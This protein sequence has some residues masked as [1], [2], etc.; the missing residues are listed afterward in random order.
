MKCCF[1]FS[2]VTIQIKHTYSKP[3]TVF[4]L[5]I[6]SKPASCECEEM[7]QAKKKKCEELCCHTTTVSDSLRINEWIGM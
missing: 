7:K 6:R 2:F 1:S 3:I 4:I 5:F